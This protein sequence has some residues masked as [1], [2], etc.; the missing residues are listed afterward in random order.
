MD[1][2]HLVASGGLLLALVIASGFVGVVAWDAD[3]E[4]TDRNLASADRTT[5][6][7]LPAECRPV[8]RSLAESGR[9][10]ITEYRIAAAPTGGVVVVRHTAD[11]GW[12]AGGVA[13]APRVSSESNLHVGGRSIDVL[14]RVTKTTLHRA[15][16]AGAVR[17]LLGV[18][19]LGVVVRGTARE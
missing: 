11:E 3:L 15:P 9:V 8:A 2:R 18:V 6:E 14:G 13:C 7:A 12:T 4:A 19:G 10:S 17:F 5:P 16:A 1:R